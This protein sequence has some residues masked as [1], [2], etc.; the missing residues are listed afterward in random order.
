MNPKRMFA[1]IVTAVVLATAGLSSAGDDYTRSVNPWIGTEGTGHATVAA[2]YPLGMVQPGPDTGT[3]S[4][5]YA[6]GYRNSDTKLYGFSQNHLNGTGVPELGD[7]L[8]LPFPGSPFPAPRSPVPFD[9]SS[10]TASPGY[11][12]VTLESGIRCEAAA[13]PR[14]AVWRFTYPD[15]ANAKL[16]VDMQWGLVWE[17]MDEHV[18][19]AGWTVRGPRALSGW[20]ETKSWTERRWNF[21][22]EA[23]AEFSVVKGDGQRR[24]AL[25]FG[26]ARTVVVRIA[27]STTDEDGAMRN[28]SEVRGRTLEQVAAD[29][30]EAW[31][32]YLARIEIP[33]ADAASVTNLYTALYHLF[34]QPNDI[35]DIDGRY[36]GADGELAQVKKGHRYFSTLSLWDTYRAAH[37][38]YTIIAPELVDDF[39]RSMVAH[40]KAVGYLPVWPLWGR[41]THCMIGNHAVP[42]LVEAVKKRLTTLTDEEVFEAIRATLRTS[43][44][45]KPKENWKALDQYGWYPFDIEP[46]EGVSRTVEGAYDDWCAARL[47]KRLA[48]DADAEFFARRAE[49]WKNVFDPEA[50]SVRGRSSDGAWRNP[51][52]PSALYGYDVPRDISEANANQYVWHVQQDSDGL[53][54]A[55]GGRSAAFAKLEEHFDCAR[56]PRGNMAD[57]TGLLGE[58]AHGNEPGHHVPYLFTVWGRP[59]RTAEIVREVFDRFYLPKPDGLCGNDDCGQM[60]AWYLFSAMGFYPF[61]PTS[62]EYVF[63][64][65]Q[66]PVVKLRTGNGGNTFSIVAKNLSREN[67]YVKSI[68]L[69]GRRIDLSSISHW[70]I[71]RGGE[72]VFEMSSSPFDVVV[73]GGTSAGIAAAVQATRDGERVVVLEPT[74]RI[75]GM[76]TGGLGQTDIGDKSAFGGLARKFY[77]DIKKHYDDPAFWTRQPRETYRPNG[78][79]AGSSDGETMW[80]FEPSA[81]LKVL[82]NWERDE[83]LRIERG[84]LL[85]RGEGGVVKED[86]RI[87]SV[88][89]LDGR[90]WRGSVFIDATYEGDLM[91]AAG[92]SYRIGREANS[93][94]GETINGIQRG[95]AVHHQIQEGVSA[96]TVPDDPSSGLLPGVEPED[97][98]RP[99]GSADNRVQAY[100]YRLC[101]TDDPENRIPFE[102]PADYDESEM[103]LLLRNIERT[104]EDTTQH[105][106]HQ[107]WNNS[108]MPNRK[109]D[110]NNRTGVSTDFIGGSW[111]WAEADYAE[112]G[113]I[114]AAHERWQRSVLWTFANHPRVPAYV[115]ADVSKWGL[116]KDEFVENGGW[117]TQLY[118][119][120][121]R[122]MVGEYVMTEH[123]CRGKAVAPRPVASA[124][125]TMDSHHVRRYADKNGRV[126]NEGDV[127]VRAGMKVPYPIDYGAII[128][129]RGECVNLLVPVCVSATHIAY[130][131]IRMEPVF[132]ALGQAAGAAASLAS[133]SGAA[134]QDVDYNALRAVLD[135][136]PRG[137]CRT[138]AEDARR[139]AEGVGAKIG[140]ARLGR[141]FVSAYLDT[142]ERTV[143]YRV[144]NGK[145]DTFVITGDIPAMW[146]RDSCAQVWPYLPL[147]RES[148]AMRRVL[149]GVLNRAF[150]CV[151]CDPYANAFL[152]GRETETMWADDMTEMKRGLH[153]RKWELD[154]L[155]YP[156]RLA[157]GYWKATGDATPFGEDYAACVRAILSTMRAEQRASR[158]FF[159]R[160]TWTPYGTLADGT[161]AP[162]KPNGMVSSAFRPSDD[163]CILPLNV[164]GNIFASDVLRKTAEVLRQT[165]GD[166]DLAAECEA[167][168]AEI[169]RAVE[170]SAVVK[171][172]KF[173]PVYA[174]EIDG[175]GGRILM[176]DANAPSLL[177][178]AYLCDAASYDRNVYDATRRMVLSEA[179]PWFFRGLSGEGVGSPHTGRDRIWPL[180]VAL[181]ALTSTNRSEIAQCIIQLRDTT[182]G[183]GVMHESHLA[184][185]PSAS[186]RGWFAWA[187]GLFA[188][189]V[190]HAL[191]T[192]VDFNLDVVEAV[193][194]NAARVLRET[195]AAP[196]RE[197]IPDL[198]APSGDSTVF[199]VRESLPSPVD[200]KAARLV[201]TIRADGTWPDVGYSGA[202]ASS[203]SAADHVKR[204][205]GLARARHTPEVVD[206]FRH[207]LKHWAGTGYRNKNWWWN[208]I[209]VP[210]EL[211]RAGLLMGEDITRDERRMIAGLMRESRIGMTG[212]NRIWLSEC[213]LMRSLLE[214]SPE[215]VRAAREAFL[216][217]VVVSGTEE[218]IQSDW[219]FHQHGNQ[220]QFGNYGLSY[221]LTVPRLADMFEGTPLAF[222]AE[223]REILRSLVAKGFAPTVW[224]GA[225]DVGAI[226]R[227]LN[228][229][230]ARIKGAGVLIAAGRL[231]VDADGVAKGLHWFPKSAYGVY[232]ADGWMA[233]VKCETKS[234]RGT[235]VV[236]EDN[237]LGAHLADGALFSSVTGDEY[238]DIFPLW[239]WR[240]IPGTTSYDVES[241]DWKSRNRAEAA[242]RDGDTVRFRLDRAGLTAET[243]WRF[244]PQ[245]VEV[246]VTDITATNGLPVVTT[247]EQSLARPN[248]A[249]RR[250]GDGIVAVNGAI[251]YF[252]PSNAVVRIET[253]T[254]SW[255]RHMGAAA[256]EEARGRVFEITI[257]HG[258]DPSGASCAWRT[259]F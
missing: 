212:Q 145:D 91:A 215:G 193:R 51:F 118:V 5:D 191:D 100:C 123:N 7:L 20:A 19:D 217:E 76:T 225:M 156:L 246:E 104:P 187:D 202:D 47:A 150:D 129:K 34:W 105:W 52:D 151:R 124:A 190:L 18:L 170:A 85:D 56:A 208:Q 111:R 73:V 216:D 84:A 108:P 101:L 134:V 143:R 131:S 176:D 181:R 120:E 164:P 63:G 154:S 14:C 32:G 57:V 53:A 97:D 135:E 203:W 23:D 30:R 166:A 72:L 197:S 200:E 41:D 234:I 239:N 230:A 157:H 224:K 211:G 74:Q 221:I 132:F 138:A 174:Y 80:T 152:D 194:Q 127:Q 1:P 49:A 163:A 144:K 61:E 237:M 48:R 167:L 31:N 122:R 59:E 192:G 223:S 12:A 247:V 249:W 147:A 213:V 87:V 136:P 114:A 39:V 155:C 229:G 201:A 42:I 222:P 188:E 106:R 82:E 38:L 75:G 257:P 65:P 252:V 109:T 250:E 253:R 55:F 17:K 95:K 92:V 242:E 93:E 58:Y 125:Y 33:G 251:R 258:V 168:A 112:R 179:N 160:R 35:T 8:I 54:A 259:A 162:F 121:A 60:S 207:A 37:P 107:P 119:R 96:Y 6:S 227:Q 218:G 148:E 10:E 43:H 81:A 128:P 240:H 232:R 116:C 189:A 69:D 83:G 236:N 182:G 103:E 243:T 214:G 13:S 2:A 165:K 171:H 141:M 15:G 36:R 44:E 4:W 241:V 88:R 209:G 26:S 94:Y 169:R 206:A 173:G 62:G 183:T 245:G 210:L 185:D 248:A 256:N 29:A 71:L 46:E 21:A 9:K 98:G 195:C 177:S 110:T 50:Q 159:K 219:S 198:D 153:E 161:V 255:R 186:T 78:Q 40:Q 90:V 89:T 146:L 79:T 140:D 22:L 64:A 178:L 99:D 67:K 3:E 204:M 130:G 115:R 133:E 175:F 235:E 117:P 28:L 228:K 231:G 205:V 24:F 220:A 86:G 254:G 158:Y 196:P 70:D 172:P 142:I 184:S 233:S 137:V 126:R 16:L 226:G 149:R 139:F 199:M 68:S 25:D 244:S 77:S 238:R 102:K 180:A 11:Y 27:L 66:I 113:R 45:G